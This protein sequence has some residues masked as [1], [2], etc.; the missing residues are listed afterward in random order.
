MR[1]SLFTT[2]AEIGPEHDILRVVC[3]PLPAPVARAWRAYDRIQHRIEYLLH[4]APSVE[5]AVQGFTKELLEAA[6]ADGEPV[7]PS[8]VDVLAARQNLDAHETTIRQLY[9]ARGW[10][11]TQVGRA[12]VA[13][14]R[15]LV[16]TLDD[17]LGALQDRAD[18]RKAAHAVPLGV[19]PDALLAA[20]PDTAAAAA[21]LGEAAGE[22]Q[23][24][25]AARRVLYEHVHP[26]AAPWLEVVA[27]GIEEGPAAGTGLVWKS[28]IL[29]SRQG[30]EPEPWAGGVGGELQFAIV[31]KIRLRVWTA[32]QLDEAGIQPPGYVLQS[33]RM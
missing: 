30:A 28:E 9:D 23:R 27:E 10:V 29:H 2:A 19:T 15:Q 20:G 7:W 13:C 11:A 16:E 22:F 26:E 6:L 31:N 33:I 4:H 21:I 1:A 17:L 32:Q 18:L 14:E 5:G 25:K 8:P 3:G 12:I 24:I